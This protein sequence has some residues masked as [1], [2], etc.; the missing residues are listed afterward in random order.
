MFWLFRRCC[1]L[2]GFI[3]VCLFF[4][5]LGR[6]WILQTT[7]C[8]WVKQQ[9]SFS[10]DIESTH[11]PIGW[12]LQLKLTGVTLQN[13]ADFP[14]M[15]ALEIP[16]VEIIVADTPWQARQF[17]INRLE[18]EISQVTLSANSSG[19]GNLTR[20]T[21][22]AQASE[23]DPR[24]IVIEELELNITDRDYAHSRRHHKVD[25]LLAFAQIMQG[26]LRR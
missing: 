7:L 10:L 14:V 16:Q 26:A 20:F 5:F 12:P 21:A 17:V 13:P 19:E 25:H 23:R 3:V 4:L 24:Y 9:T 15:T 6:D 1:T 22:I 18:I 8:W 11:L 2:I